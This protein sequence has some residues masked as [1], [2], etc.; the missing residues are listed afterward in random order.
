MVDICYISYKIKWWTL[1]KRQN[2]ERRGEVNFIN[3]AMWHLCHYGVNPL[4]SV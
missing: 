3:N 4:L 2:R 1:V